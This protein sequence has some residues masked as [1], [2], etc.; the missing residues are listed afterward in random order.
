MS[1]AARRASF[2]AYMRDQYK[3][4][5]KTLDQNRAGYRTQ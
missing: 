3:G 2:R 4:I 1:V 5:A